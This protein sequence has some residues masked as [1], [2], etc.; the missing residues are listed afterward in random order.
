MNRVVRILA[1]QLHARLPHDC[2]IEI[3]DLVQAGNVGLLQAK[4]N[5]NPGRGAPLSGYAKFRIRG[6]M[7]DVVRRSAR[8]ARTTGV[9]SRFREDT[10]ECEAPASGAADN[11]PQATYV[12]HQRARIIGEEI[13]R[14]P[15]R[16]RMVVRLRYGG[17][18]TLR[19]IGDALSVNESRACQ[20]HQGALTLLRRALRNRGVRELSQL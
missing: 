20:I 15:P 19:E 13:K 1:G 3:S 6:E 4:L 7:L 10:A 5:Y 8:N 14:L 17:E 2:G 16:Y 12:R 18:M 11:S 9:A